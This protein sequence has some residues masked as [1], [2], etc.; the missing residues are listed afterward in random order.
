MSSAIRGRGTEMA[1]TQIMCANCPNAA[2]FVLLNG[3]EVEVYCAS[4]FDAVIV[5]LARNNDPF[6]MRG[7][8]QDE[9]P[10]A[11]A[12]MRVFRVCGDE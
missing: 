5:D 8:A 7:V 2:Q 6:K 3:E 12:D 1:T 11:F 4:D 10:P 9:K